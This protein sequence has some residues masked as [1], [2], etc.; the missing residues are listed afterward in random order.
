MDMKYDGVLTISTGLSRMETDWKPKRMMWGELC[1]QLS[2]TRYTAETEAE[3]AAMDKSARG[4]I[5]DVGGFV[6]GELTGGQRKNG[7][8]KSRQLLALDADFGTPD[9]WGELHAHD[10]Q[11][12]GKGAEIPHVLP[13]HAQRIG[14]GI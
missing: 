10:A 9:L 13:A 2:S 12:H 3:Y 14:G 8:V 1:Q 4:V 11:P 5:K 6:G 7:S